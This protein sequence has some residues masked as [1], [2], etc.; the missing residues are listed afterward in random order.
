MAKGAAKATR[1]IHHTWSTVSW[2]T[3]SSSSL[4]GRNIALPAELTQVNSAVDALTLELEGNALAQRERQ[5][6]RQ[7]EKKKKKKKKLMM[8]MMMMMMMM[9]KKIQRG[10]LKYFH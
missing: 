1:D 2:S 9:S 8:M 6:E 7:R 5:R 4:L 10:T 3:V